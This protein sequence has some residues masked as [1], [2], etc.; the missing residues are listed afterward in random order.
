MST[1][2]AVAVL[3]EEADPS[4]KLTFH[5]NPTTIA[6]SRAVQY[7]R[8]P[9]QANDPPVQFTGAGPTTMTLQVFLDAAGRREPA[10]VQP[11][12]DLLV[13]WTSVPDVTNPGDGPPKV[14][15]T[16]GHLSVNGEQTLVGNVSQ[17]KVTIERFDRE[18]RPLRVVAELTL[19]SAQTEPQRT[20]PTSG[21]E[22]SRRRHVLRRGETLASVAWS[23]LGDPGAWR[24]VAELNDVDDPTRLRAGRE[25]LLPDAPER[26]ALGLRR[27]A[28]VAPAWRGDAR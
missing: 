6:F 25:L 24:A 26:G 12:I 8:Q 15:F 23:R 28:P 17:L 21:A 2:R 1:G 22:R 20:N 5:Y 14:T 7:N 27:A 16:W 19:V 9:R 4:R 18:G 3:A 11:E 13:S 10:S